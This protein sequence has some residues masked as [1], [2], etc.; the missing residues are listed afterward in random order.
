MPT[1]SNLNCPGMSSVVLVNVN[2]TTKE[3][4]DLDMIYG[5]TPT[6]GSSVKFKVNSK[7][8]TPMNMYVQYKKPSDSRL[9]GWS[10]AC[11][12]QLSV[13]GCSPMATEIEADCL[14]ADGEPYILIQVYYLD[15]TASSPLI[16][17]SVKVDQCCE[18]VPA[19]VPPNAVA[20][21]SFILRCECPTPTN[22]R[23]LE[24]KPINVEKI[25][26]LFQQQ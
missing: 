10:Q 5:I 13:S 26:A 16:F 25:Q 18:N 20:Q 7:F 19:Q 14:Y 21:Y 1:G 15:P 23:R 8:L 4:D 24:Q 9:G 12:D 11:E 17:G 2:G 6:D 22:L 3:D